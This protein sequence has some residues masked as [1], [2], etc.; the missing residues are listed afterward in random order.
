MHKQL[1]AKRDS[2][3]AH[4]DASE[5][6]AKVVPPGNQLGQSGFIASRL[7]WTVEDSLLGLQQFSTISKIISEQIRKIEQ[8]I[9]ELLEKLYD[10]KNMPESE[11]QI[12]YTDG[13]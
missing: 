8:D 12:D 13:L 1:L 2:F 10:S 4:S 11:L 5:R 3:I 6:I 9:R 7:G